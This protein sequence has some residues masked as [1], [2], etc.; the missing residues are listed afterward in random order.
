MN[1]PEQPKALEQIIPGWRWVERV[2]WVGPIVALAAGIVFGVTE[3]HS[4][5]DCW[6]GLAAG[7]Q[8]LQSETF[9]KYDT[10]SY[11]FY[12]ALWY[13]Q[14]W[15]THVWLRWL[16]DTFGRDAVIWGTW[17]LSSSILLLVMLATHFRTR[18]WL[19]AV[20]AAA[21]AGYGIREFVS[22]RPATVGFFCMAA[23][24]ALICA[25]EGQGR[26]R[27]WWPIVLLLPLLL[28]WGNAHGSFVMAYALLAI[29]LGHNLALWAARLEGPTRWAA[30]LVL[31][32]IPV[33][34]LALMA[35]SQHSMVFLDEPD[36]TFA[37][38]PDKLQ[39]DK[40]ILRWSPVVLYILY[41]ATIQWL[42]PAPRISLAQA[43]ALAACLVLGVVLTGTLGPYGWQNFTHGEKVAA[44]RR[45]RTVAEWLPLWAPRNQRAFPNMDRFFRLLAG[46]A[47]VLALCAVLGLAGRLT[48]PRSERPTPGIR[49]P[50]LYDLAVVL[51][52]LGMTSWSRRFAPMFLLFAL[53]A[54]ATAIVWLV[55]S[56]PR[57][58]RDVGRAV[59]L[60]TSVGLGFYF[61]LYTRQVVNRELMQL[62]RRRGLSL[63]EAVTRYDAVPD[64]GIEYL[65]RNDLKVNL[66]CEWT[67]AGAV[68]MRAP[69]VRVYID[70]RSQ[71]VYTEAHYDKYLALISGGRTP[72]MALAL[73]DEPPATDA[74]LLRLNRSTQRLW[75]TL[76]RHPQW[77]LVL[78]GRGYG[79]FLRRPSAA[80]AKVGRLVRSGREWRP[81][82][83]QAL[84]SLGLVYIMTQPRDPAR[85]LEC[86]R[87][88]IEQDI[89][90]VG[91]WSAWVVQTLVSQG[92][93]ADAR[94]FIRRQV[95]RLQS[96]G[97]GTLPARRRQELLKLL[98]QVAR[99]I[100]AP[101][102]RGGQR[103]RQP[104]TRPGP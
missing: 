63:F 95:R 33:V 51:V 5:T 18:S 35:H 38:L 54:A 4:S 77:V 100:P 26:R 30:S 102:Q 31:L 10:F 89:D 11:A 12:Q 81:D 84:A 87:R 75:T 60:L 45:F 24:W 44:S 59:V 13:N 47:G 101:D 71:Q 40:T 34:V 93:P 3:V 21:V 2:L 58:L 57:L 6:I 22:P 103:P 99:A 42:R 19:A 37:F 68:M 79:L 48:G 16:H 7:R 1:G 41:W 65:V 39:P 104:H 78:H 15:L 52:A 43:G 73:L 94:A 90:L 76:W 17:A 83:P 29:Y 91:S 74:V 25:L 55:Q 80:L 92:R 23:L 97:A 70:G 82:T 20:L 50:T 98:Q 9:P 32:I 27:R 96:A 53:P 62:V 86:W 88:A 64:E 67:I 49:P 69:Q 28:V 85:A 72:Q 8:I 56:L 14:N 36:L 61:A 46:G 66:F